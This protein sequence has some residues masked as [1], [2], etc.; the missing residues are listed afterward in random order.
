MIRNIGV[1][2][3]NG[4]ERLDVEGP[5]GV[6]GWIRQEAPSI[7]LLSKDGRPVRDHLLGR[8]IH[9]DD[10]TAHCD[11]GEFDLLLVP[12]GDLSQIGVTTR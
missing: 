7:R 5:C 3:F 1:V 12:G 11:P 2:V 4:V 9:V 6:F 8:E 10:T